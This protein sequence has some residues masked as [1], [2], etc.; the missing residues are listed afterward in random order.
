M[1]PT[2]PPAIAAPLTN[3]F[4]RFVCFVLSLLLPYMACIDWLSYLLL[5]VCGRFFDF[6]FFWFRCV[7][8]GVRSVW[9]AVWMASSKDL[10][11]LDREANVRS[12]EDSGGGLER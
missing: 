10:V 5:L 1:R 4:R 3:S 12:E 8:R 9:F 7:F 6:L 11:I 2:T